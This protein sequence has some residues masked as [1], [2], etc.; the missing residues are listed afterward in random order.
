ME[1]QVPAAPASTEVLRL[2]LEAIA[3][4]LVLVDPQGVICWTNAAWRAVA[5][6]LAAGGLGCLY[7]EVCARGCGP[8]AAALT[9]AVVGLRSLYAGTASKYQADYVRPQPGAAGG[10]WWQLRAS[11]LADG[12]QTFILVQHGE[13]T[14]SM[15]P[16]A[17]SATAVAQSA[18]ADLSAGRFQQMAVALANREARLREAERIAGLGTWEVDVKSDQFVASPML[19]SIYGLPATPAVEAMQPEHLAVAALFQQ[20]I[21][22]DDRA[23]MKTYFD[24]LRRGQAPPPVTLRVLRPDGSERIVHIEARAYPDE[25]GRIA[26]IIGVTQDLTE[27][28]LAERALQAS[29]RL[30]RAIFDHTPIGIQV[31]DVDG[32]TR[33]L[34][35]AQRAMFGLPSLDYIVGT[36]NILTDPLAIAVGSP[37]RFREALS[38]KVVTAL[39]QLV[40]LGTPLN[41]W[42]SYKKRMYLDMTFFPLTSDAG[43]VTAV[44]ELIQDVS[45]RKAAQDALR[46]SEERLRLAY[47]AE[48][49]GYW[50]WDLRSQSGMGS[51]EMATI[52]G[53]PSQPVNLGEELFVPLILPEERES[54][55]ATLKDRC[56]PGG[57]DSFSFNH[58]VITHSGEI[59]WVSELG[60]II[61]DADGHAKRIVGTIR[62]VTANQVAAQ[63]RQKFF[64]LIENSLDSIA[65]ASLSG[66]LVYLNPAGR[67]LHGFALDAPLNG[68]LLWP[69]P[70][71]EGEVSQSEVE[72]IVAE[73]DRWEG[74]TTIRHAVTG[75]AIDVRR[76]IFVVREPHSGTH[77]CLAAITQDI[78]LTKR[79]EEALRDAKE[80]AEA[81]SRAKSAFVATVSHEL[82]T[83]MNGVLGMLEVALHREAD[84]AQRER[85]QLAKGAAETLLTLLD[86]LLDFSKME[87][88]KLELFL[89]E[90]PLKTELLRMV[91]SFTERA[92]KK[93]LQLTCEIDLGDVEYVLADRGRLRQVLN[94]LI[95]N[96]IKFTPCGR[97][98]LR[99][100]VKSPSKGADRLLYVEVEDT[101][102]GIEA[103]VLPRLFR[104]FEQGDS[105]TTRLFGGSGLGLSIVKQLVSLMGGEVGV[106]SSY[107]CG[108][109]FWFRVP[110]RITLTPAAISGRELLSQRSSDSLNKRP[111][112]I[113][114]AE[115]N[116]VSQE[117]ARE[118]L[119]MLG[120]QVDVVDSGAAAREAARNKSYDVIFMDL[121]MPEVDGFAG[122]A[123]IRADERNTGRR[124][125]I[126]AVTA[127]AMAEDREAC[128][129]AGMDGHLS[130]PLHIGQLRAV[131]DGLCSEGG[132][133]ARKAGPE[134]VNLGRMLEQLGGDVGLVRQ[135][136]TMVAERSPPLLSKLKQTFEAG[137]AAAASVAAHSLRG[138]LSYVH[139]DEVTSALWGLE[140]GTKTGDLLGSAGQLSLVCDLVEGL[141][142]ELPLVMTELQSAAP[143]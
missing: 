70:S 59:R 74:E 41:R 67:R 7:T 138:M 114:V 42:N 109:L 77:L 17:A 60:R 65:M 82:R 78:R 11:R 57:G 81:G 51:A 72:R 143:G 89:S 100:Y 92:E 101:G 19:Y 127:M 8:A 105:S 14:V 71:G 39:E 68:Q 128:L 120:H 18:E 35:E 52:L 139:S 15:Q 31:F 80:R 98:T 134:T 130:K 141:L 103:D 58:H 32:T 121:H 5:E 29:E 135:T 112:R 53:F 50:D 56:A 115:D 36:F 117:V 132:E 111:K 69:E 25:S 44:V 37:P 104:P 97:V 45:E 107:C 90:F 27:R 24:E 110:L 22:L 47:L 119:R 46:I 48:G 3:D 108:S 83:P 124:T 99:A 54:M 76:S 142:R 87:A 88:G 137:N 106:S 122:T 20:S 91:E 6:S 34:N 55:L 85:L 136:L 43:E 116:E 95:G 12:D 64:A 9:Q 63:E 16:A 4:P 73:T 10:R 40:E 113:L 28:K 61:R 26:R 102:I 123:L 118:L 38:G 49:I 129:S 84:A 131:L 23:A 86:D 13:L 66:E 1:R 75:E 126:I 2:A 94:N 125:P 21:H 33:Q 62:D 79:N 133:P 140:N 93:Q 30:K 96:A